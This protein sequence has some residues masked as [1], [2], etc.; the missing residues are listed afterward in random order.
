VH[1]LEFDDGAARPTMRLMASAISRPRAGLPSIN[2][3]V[4][5]ERRPALSAGES[6]SGVSTVMR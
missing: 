5:P 1:D 3:M 4:S 6:S 2:S